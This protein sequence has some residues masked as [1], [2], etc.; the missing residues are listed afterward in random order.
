MVAQGW[1]ESSEK[2]SP[3]VVA[4]RSRLSKTTMAGP[5]V[6]MMSPPS[7]PGTLLF[8]KLSTTSS[9]CKGARL[10]SSAI[11][12]TADTFC[13]FK[14]NIASCATFEKLLA[15]TVAA[16]VFSASHV[17]DGEDSHILIVQQTKTEEL[18][19]KYREA[20]SRCVGCGSVPV[21]ALTGEM[22]R[23]AAEAVSAYNRAVDNRSFRDDVS[24]AVKELW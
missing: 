13:S 17:L 15:R 22:V 16:D 12:V 2:T 3:T 14:K 18:L 24:R 7:P 1:T 20:S 5:D 19:K 11:L 6:N 9:D 21:A 8:R 4:L 10:D 23:D